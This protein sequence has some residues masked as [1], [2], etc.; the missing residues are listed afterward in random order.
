MLYQQLPGHAKNR[1]GSPE[2]K[3]LR[4]KIEVNRFTQP[5]FQTDK[6]VTEFEIGLRETYRNYS[7]NIK[8]QN[9]YVS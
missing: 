5:L 6:W 7:L 4:A 1:H 2:L 8:P 3:L 9:I